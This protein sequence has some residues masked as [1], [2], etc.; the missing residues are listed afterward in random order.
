NSVVPWTMV[1]WGTRALDAGV[2]TILNSTAPIVTFF[3]TFAVTRPEAVTFR[4]LVGVVA[5]MIGICLI[6]GMQA[7]AGLGEQLAAQIALLLAAVC[8]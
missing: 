3:L 4:K 2:A 1:A 7:L 5:G 8:Y 6:V